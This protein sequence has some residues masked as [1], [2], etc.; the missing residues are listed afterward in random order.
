[1]FPLNK[2]N[3]SKGE[4]IYMGLNFQR[5]MNFFQIFRG[6]GEKLH[7]WLLLGKY[8]GKGL[9]FLF[10]PRNLWQEYSQNDGTLHQER[11]LKG[12]ESFLVDWQNIV[13]LVTK[14]EIVDM[15]LS[16]VPYKDATL[17]LVNSH[18][19]A[20]FAHFVSSYITI[21]VSLLKEG[22]NSRW[23][24]CEF[25]SHLARGRGKILFQWMF[26]EWMIKR[27]ASTLER[28][29]EHKP[30]D[31]LTLGKALDGETS[32][33]AVHTRLNLSPLTFIISSCDS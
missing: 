19:R 31:S 20:L 16:L 1:M 18:Q 17:V 14:A 10:D 8:L 9:T 32:I 26:A 33:N 25:N 7:L 22:K 11:N 5:G 27:L 6:Q 12:L 23:Q 4:Y 3:S 29:M 30:M 28:M 13:T 24:W 15:I 21:P 2:V